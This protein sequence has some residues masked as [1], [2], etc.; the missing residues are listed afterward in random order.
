[1]ASGSGGVSLPLLALL[2]RIPSSGFDQVR[3]DLVDSR[4]NTGVAREAYILIEK[5][6]SRLTG[7]LK[8]R[9]MTR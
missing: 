1:M 7:V 4:C 5:S 3:R 6:S 9:L 2:K 8:A